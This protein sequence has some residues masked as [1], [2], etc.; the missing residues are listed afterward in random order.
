MSIKLLD[1]RAAWLNDKSLQNT[2]VA[3]KTSLTNGHGIETDIRDH[4]GQLVIAHD[5]P[6]QD[7]LPFEE[8]L[9]LYRDLKSSSC[10]ALNVKSDGLQ[11]GVK[12]LLQKYSIFNYFVFDA[13]I[14][15]NVMYHRRELSFYLRHSDIEQCPSKSSPDLY[16]SPFCKGVWLDDFAF[17]RKT[18]PDKF[19]ITKD[20]IKM[21]LNKGKSIALVSPELH[22]WGRDLQSPIVWEYWR[23]V[24][25]LLSGGDLNSIYICTDLPQQ[26]EAY[27][28]DY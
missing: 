20:V 27:F 3:F 23:H 7:S 11:N 9:N 6:T 2:M 26:A 10:L 21:H 1:H 25:K 24:F 4:N 18:S 17:S 8:L 19:F 13:S 22:P 28:N 16:E 15:D 12:T 14:P 5:L